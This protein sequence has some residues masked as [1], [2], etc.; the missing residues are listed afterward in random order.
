MNPDTGISVK[1]PLNAYVLPLA[2]GWL[3]GHGS[4][5]AQGCRILHFALDEHSELDVLAERT[6]KGWVATATLRRAG[7]I[8]CVQSSGR[9]ITSIQAEALAV[10]ALAESQPLGSSLAINIESLLSVQ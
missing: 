4:V 2:V 10:A 6:D 8:A 3:R 5:T 1:P 7:K 9:T